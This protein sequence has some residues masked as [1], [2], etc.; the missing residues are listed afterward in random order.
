MATK[1]NRKYLSH[2]HCAPLLLSTAARRKR[3]DAVFCAPGEK[4]KLSGTIRYSHRTNFERLK[5]FDCAV[6]KEGIRLNMGAN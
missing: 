3:D 4:L 6:R 1:N 2:H 5:T